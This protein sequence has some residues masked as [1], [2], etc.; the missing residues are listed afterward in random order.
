MASVGGVGGGVSLSFS[1]RFFSYET[2]KVLRVRDRRLGGLY[3]LF[4]ATILIYIATS[5]IFQQRYLKTENIINGAVRVTLKA[6][7]DGIATSDYCNTTKP[8]IYWN[9]NDILY[10]PG[11]GGALITTRAQMT[12]YGPFS[13]QTNSDTGTCNVNIPKGSGCDPYNAPSTLLLPTSLVADIE[14]FTLM[15]EHSIRGQASGVQMRSGNM[16]SGLLRDSETGNVVKTFNDQSR[17]ISVVEGGNNS[18]R[19]VHLAGD[20]MTVG[21]FLRASG[22]NL[23]EI[24]QSPT[25]SAGETVR[26]SGVVVIVVIQYAAKGWNPNKISY[27]YLPKAIAD[28]EYKV[29]ETIRDFKDGNRVEINRH[30]IRIIFSQTGQLGQFSLMTLLTNLV[31]AIALFKVANIIVELMMLRLHPRKK[32]YDRA[33]FETTNISKRKDRNPNG[34]GISGGKLKEMDVISQ[35]KMEQG[36]LGELGDS[37]FNN[38]DENTSRRDP[39]ATDSSMDEECDV[40]E[41]PTTEISKGTEP[42]RRSAANGNKSNTLSRTLSA[43][44]NGSGSGGSGIGSRYNSSQ[45]HTLPISASGSTHLI[46]RASPL[47]TA[48]RHGNGS[49]DEIEIETRFGPV[50]P[51]EFKGFNPGG[52]DLNAS[53]QSGNNLPP[54]SG[55]SSKTGMT[56]PKAMSTIVSDDS[57]RS[58]TVMQAISPSPV[59]FGARQDNMEEYISGAVRERRRSRKHILPKQGASPNKTQET[60]ASSSRRSV[61]SIFTLT[62]SSSSTS[63]SSIDNSPYYSKDNRMNSSSMSLGI[64]S[65][66]HSSW[67]F[68]APESPL[69]GYSS[70]GDS[71]SGSKPVLDRDD[72]PGSGAG[73]RKIGQKKR[74][75]EHHTA[76]KMQS[77]QS[78]SESTTSRSIFEMGTSNSQ[79]SFSL[80]SYPHRGTDKGKQ[81]NFAKLN[82]SK[83]LSLFDNT[84]HP[85][86][87][88]LPTGS[89]EVSDRTTSETVYNAGLESFQ[90]PIPAFLTQKSGSFLELEGS[91]PGWNADSS[92]SSASGKQPQRNDHLH[93]L[94]AF[95]SSPCLLSGAAT[96]SSHSHQSAILSPTVILES[97]STESHP[98]S[99]SMAPVDLP[100]RSADWRFNDEEVTTTTTAIHSNEAHIEG[101]TTRRSSIPTQPSR[102]T[103]PSTASS[104]QRS[105]PRSNLRFERVVA[106]SSSRT[107]RRSSEPELHRG[108][109]SHFAPSSSF[110]ST[111]EGINA[112]SV[113]STRMTTNSTNPKYRSSSTTTANNNNNNNTNNSVVRN[114]ASSTTP[115]TPTTDYYPHPT[116]S[117][118]TS[119][120]TSSCTATLAGTGVRVLGRSITMIMADNTELVLRRSEPLILS[121]GVGEEKAARM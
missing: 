31:A 113:R 16:V 34:S 119:P 67:S 85:F 38:R 57:L 56:T 60:G 90:L 24:S 20:V 120:I 73:S 54:R 39:Y 28:Q 110:L 106:E 45:Q 55:S 93:N 69:G 47:H 19:S 86:S 75:K 92:S 100:P 99:Y 102:A 109:V 27:E 91:F 41:N 107:T 77:T 121:E 84:T 88:Q 53:P 30:G 14:R 74:R 114:P 1:D 87:T 44:S 116:S 48:S 111:T 29:I 71:I 46:N 25:A 6:P 105:N 18:S 3:R 15:L 7:S 21:E 94:R 89:K 26:S 33:K 65:G 10:E 32:I 22:V 80:S 5:I 62:P 2:F 35:D 52:L 58:A 97:P 66:F 70:G 117:Y 37:G 83:A 49:S 8:C 43:K 17:H 81:P 4:Q 12:Q 9:E 78:N 40:Y 36:G 42:T 64:G 23:E 96:S 63:L 76:S 103:T 108:S 82:D 59:H 11:V 68:G 95:A 72:S 79:S 101:S 61:R 98:A 112:G 115:T 118:F 51:N 104:T 50:R 13:N